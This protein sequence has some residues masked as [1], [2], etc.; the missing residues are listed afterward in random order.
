MPKSPTHRTKE[1][2]LEQGCKLVAIV[3]HW[4][5]FAKV[6]QDLFGFIDIL[7]VRNG[8]VVGIQATSGTNLS[9]RLKKC[10]EHENLP[11]WLDAAEFEIWAWTVKRRKGKRPEVKCEVR[12]IRREALN[13][14]P[15]LL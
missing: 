9:A 6:R 2:L 8:V 12:V 1:T 5:S 13:K 4:N 10:R 7:A 14:E 11:F 3:E 15:L